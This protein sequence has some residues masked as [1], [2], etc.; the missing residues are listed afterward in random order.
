MLI[1]NFSL[2]TNEAH[3]EF[4]I[5]FILFFL[6]MDKIKNILEY[7]INLVIHHGS[8]TI[9]TYEMLFLA[10]RV[11]YFFKSSNPILLPI[12]I[13][14]VYY[15]ILGLIDFYSSSD[16]I[17]WKSFMLSLLFYSLQFIFI[18][19]IILNIIFSH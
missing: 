15:Y 19:H 16:I 14:R 6:R 8:V 4:Q 10:L 17:V 9:V 12:W 11:L 1:L 13:L 18:L 3:F 5:L 7:Q 2:F